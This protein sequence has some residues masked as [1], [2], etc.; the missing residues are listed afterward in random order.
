MSKYSKFVFADNSFVIEYTK[1]TY[2]RTATGKS[3]KSNPDKIEFDFVTPE[4]YQNYINSIPFFSNFGGKATCRAQYG[5][6]FA[7][8]LPTNVTTVSPD[9]NIKIVVR[10]VFSNK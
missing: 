4:F 5:Y 1:K 8:Y 3:W 7:G 10:F 6:T 2:T 9:G